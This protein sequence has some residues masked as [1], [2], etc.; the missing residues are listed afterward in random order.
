MNHFLHTRVEYEY[1]SGDGKK[2]TENIVIFYNDYEVYEQSNTRYNE[3]FSREPFYWVM[4]EM[5]ERSEPRDLDSV[6]F[7]SDT[8]TQ[9]D[10]EE[11]L[12]TSKVFSEVGVGDVVS[13][14][15]QS[16]RQ[17]ER[18]KQDYNNFSKLSESLIFKTVNECKDVEIVARLN[19]LAQQ[20]VERGNT[21]IGKPQYFSGTRNLYQT[22]LKD[23]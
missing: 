1:F 11:C 15:V 13:N 10:L 22:I 7:Y 2:A 8:L 3:P 21:P 20:F 6:T 5:F 12:H 17:Q 19:K 9:K 16:G 4:Y 18:Y 14:A 23:N